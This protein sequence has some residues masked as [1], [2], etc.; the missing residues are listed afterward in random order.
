M[1][2]DLPIVTR[3]QVAF[4]RIAEMSLQFSNPEPHLAVEEDGRAAPP[5]RSIELKGAAYA[6]PATEG[7]GPF[8]LGP[9]D[10]RI[11]RGECLFIVGDNGSGKTTLIKLL[12]GLYAP[13]DGT[14]L[15]NGEPVTERNRDDY[16]Q[17]FTTIFADYFLFEDLPQAGGE[18]PAEA[19]SYLQQLELAHKVTVA[20]GRFSTLDLSTGQRK[21]LAL[22][23]AWVERRPVL[24]FDEWAADQDPTF[25]RLFYTRL[26]PD[27]KRLGRTL[28]VISH[29]DRYFHAADRIVR[30]EEGRIVE[31][32]VPAAGPVR[33][34]A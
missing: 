24:V 20:D 11:D 4:R 8:V 23:Q 19:A 21:R 28:I 17:L 29:D 13:Q 22:I 26:L 7:A 5:M 33:E 18:L 34:I 9:V 1:I 6:F 25:R 16:R 3:A 27:L 2:G 12:L 32:Q 10:L 30:L 15:L 14:L 31:G